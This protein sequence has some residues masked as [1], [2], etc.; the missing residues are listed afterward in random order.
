MTEAATKQTS[1]ITIVPATVNGYAVLVF[2]NKPPGKANLDA[3]NAFVQANLLPV[4]GWRLHSDMLQPLSIAPLAADAS[5]R[6]IIMPNG[7]IFDLDSAEKRWANYDQ[8]SQFL[9]RV[10]LA[11]KPEPETI[12]VISG[13]RAPTVVHA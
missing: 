9:V 7:K 6:Y 3:V 13:R 1:D 8:F 5:S 2:P 10:W 12:S 11:A 4:V